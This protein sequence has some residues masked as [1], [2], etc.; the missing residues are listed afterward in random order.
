MVGD[1]Y[2]LPASF[3]VTFEP[4]VTFKEISIDIIA[5]NSKE[6]TEI[7][8]IYMDTSNDT[9]VIV[10]PDIAVIYIE[11]ASAKSKS[12]YIGI[13]RNKQ[14]RL[15]QKNNTIWFDVL[16]DCKKKKKKKT[17]DF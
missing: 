4:S 11:D 5:D 15:Q 2:A 17:Q 9:D 6:D 1:D 3:I 12:P 7:F 8:E 10:R 16:N 13:W 14:N